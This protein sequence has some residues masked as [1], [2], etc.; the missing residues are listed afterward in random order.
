MA[1]T[2]LIPL[3]TGKGRSFATAIR[4]IIGYV[5]NPDKTEG[6]RLVTGYQC[7]PGIA[8]AEFLLFKNLYRQK[9]GRERGADDVIAY[10]LRQSFVPG[11]ITPEEANRLGQELAK[12]FTKGNNAFIV[13]T[14]TDKKHIHNHIIISAVT[15]DQTRKLRNFWGSSKAIRRLNDMIC[16]ENGY[17]I[18]ENPN[19]KGQTYDEWLGSKADSHRDLL[20]AAIDA[21]LA[22]KPESFEALMEL[23]RQVGYEVKG[24]PANPS[25]R[26][27][28]QKRFIRMDSLG[29]GYSA[30]ELRTVIA[31]ER[32]HTPKRRASREDRTL[33]RNDRR[34]G[35]ERTANHERQSERDPARQAEPSRQARQSPD[36]KTGA[37]PQE[38]KPRTNQLLID[39]QAK[40]AQGKGAGY[41]NWAKKFN[42]KQM[43]QTMSYL[44]EN[45][46][47]DYAVLSEKAAAASARFRQL[48]TEIKDAEKR[49]TEIAVLRTHIINYAKTHDTYAAYRQAGYSK[50]FL[51]AH[52]GDIL[53]HKA[54]KQYFDAQGMKKLPKIK[55]LQAEYSAL[56]TKKKAS[57]GEYRKAREEMQELVTAK[58]N[59]DRIPGKE[60]EAHDIQKEKS[61]QR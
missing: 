23:L 3:H 32:E 59:V 22:Q 34:T 49:M 1:T 7:N 9:T 57:Y 45:G 33:G 58:A 52:E 56:L 51:A 24:N 48:S 47:M 4:D 61:E 36:Q 53:L 40:L 25:L 31:G 20:C 15:L 44:K 13:A 16:V 19:P 42:L 41:A 6:G 46:L 35:N 10:H 60:P 5:K 11:E 21:A 14:H 38:K 18:V 28:A 30:A 8:G 12:R 2:R 29:P 50:K 43:A 55:D 26:G 17:S 54:A 39:V 27:G 37:A